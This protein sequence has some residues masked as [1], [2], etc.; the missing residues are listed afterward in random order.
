[1][2]IVNLLKILFKNIN[3]IRGTNVKTQYVVAKIAV[4]KQVNLW[5]IMLISASSI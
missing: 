1:M 2:E 3:T 5:K 4:K